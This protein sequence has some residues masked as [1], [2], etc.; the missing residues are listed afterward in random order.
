MKPW[1]HTASSF[2]WVTPRT[3]RQNTFSSFIY[4]FFCACP[5]DQELWS[6][7]IH[8]FYL[9]TIIRPTYMVFVHLFFLSCTSF[10]QESWP[11]LI[12][13][14]Y[15]RTIIRPIHLVFFQL[16]F[17]LCTTIRAKIMVLF[18]LFFLVYATIRPRIVVLID[19]FIL[20]THDHSTKFYGLL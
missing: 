3:K 4:S 11:W 14:F 17:L 20:F 15:L 10:N 2:L 8:F 13:F 9:H 12:Y 6:S 16:F 7:L 1:T 5:F 18:H 19:L